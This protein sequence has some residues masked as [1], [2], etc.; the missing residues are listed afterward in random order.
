MLLSHDVSSFV[1]G[2]QR[3]CF[4]YTDTTAALPQHSAELRMDNLAGARKKVL[5]TLPRK[6]CDT[7]WDTRRTS[8]CPQIRRVL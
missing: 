1:P 7:F 4:Q 8:W 6:L 3:Y 5:L 2:L